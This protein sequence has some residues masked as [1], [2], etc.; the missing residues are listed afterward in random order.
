MMTMIQCCPKRN[1]FEIT[2][3]S[4]EIWNH[5]LESS[6][7]WPVDIEVDSKQNSIILQALMNTDNSLGQNS[8]CKPSFDDIKPSA[9]APLGV[10]AAPVD[11]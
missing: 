7:K 10:G 1:S 11:V 2:N 6:Y 5:I 9:N 3:F 4:V 8:N